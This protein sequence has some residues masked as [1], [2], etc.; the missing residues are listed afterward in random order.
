[1]FTMSEDAEPLRGLA[2]DRREPERAKAKKGLG[3]RLRER[4]GL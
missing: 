2:R 3:K 4:L 1:M